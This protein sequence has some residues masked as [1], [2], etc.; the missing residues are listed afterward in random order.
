MRVS[1]RSQ[2]SGMVPSTLAAYFPRL[3]RRW[4]AERPERT[5]SE[6]DGSVV[7]VDV[8]GFT[9]LSERLARLGKIG[10]EEL[11]V[12]ITECFSALLAVADADGGSL[13][14]FGGD[15]LL[16]LFTGPQHERHACGAAVG[17]RRTL[18]QVGRLRTP[19]GQVTLRMSVGVHSGTFHFFLVGDS[20]RELVLTGP[21]TSEVVRMESAAAA[22][23]ILVSPATAAGLPASLVGAEKGPG[24]LLRRQPV[25]DAVE[26][27]RDGLELSDQVLQGYL[28]L[29][30]RERFRAALPE[31][32]HRLVTVGFLH[33]AGA[34]ALVTDHGTDATAAA[35]DDLVRVVQH[36]VDRHGVSFLASDVDRDG[37]KLILAAGAPVAY[38]DDEQG[39]LLALREIMDADHRLAVRAGV[40]R[41]AVFAGDVGPSFRRTYTVMGD[42]VNLAARLMGKAA[43]G[44]I[45]ATGGVL[46][47]TRIRFAT[48]ALEPFHVKGKRRPVH[49]HRVGRVLGTH[50]RDLDAR[51]PL[52]GR[53]AEVAQL[54]AA[55]E[56][57]R[58]G[59]GRLVELVG[60]PG[61]GKSRLLDEMRDR[62]Q[63]MAVHGVA[64][65][66]YESATPYGPFRALLRAL[67]AVPEQTGAQES[68]ALLLNVLHDG[69]PDLLPWAPLL[70]VPLGGQLPATEETAHLDGPFRRQRLHHAVTGLLTAL[71]PAPALLAFEDVHWMDE[72]SADL[73]HH[74]A[75]RVDERPWVV[76]VTRRDAGTGFQARPAP[77]VTSVLLEPLDAEHAAG[78][79]DLVLGAARLPAHARAALAARSG[80]NPLFLAELAGAIDAAAG[81]EELPESVEG[82]ISARIDRLA[83][84]DRTLLR[85]LAVLGQTFTRDLAEAVLPAG[86]RV[87]DDEAWAGLEEFL[88][89]QGGTVRFRHAMIR[90]AAYQAL[91]FRLRRTLHAEAGAAIEAAAGE[92][93][94]EPAALLSYHFFHS[95]RYAEAWRHSLAAAEQAAAVYA[96]ADA[97]TFYQRALEAARGVPDLGPTEVARIH[98]ALGD[99]RDLMGAFVEAGASYRS[100]RRLVAG[101]APAEAR[102]ALKIAKTQG[103]LRRYSQALRSIRRA[104][105]TLDGVD[106]PEAARQRAQL[107]VWHGR[108]CQE[109]GRHAAAI[110]WC[111]EGIADAEAAGEPEAA[112]HAYRV[113]DWA[114]MDL[115]QPEQAVHSGKALAIYEELG[116]LP[117][118]AAVLNNLGGIAYWQGRWN[119]ALGLYERAGDLWTRTG[120]EVGVAFA[121]ANI[122]E[123]LCE[124]GKLGEAEALLRD[125]MRTWQ[126]VGHRPRVAHMKSELARVAARAGR[127]GDA[128]QLFDEAREES[129]D[130]GARVDVLE[131]NARVAESL[132]Y[133]GRGAEALRLA[134]TALEQAQ[135]LGGVGAQSP[136]LHRIRGYALMQRGERAAAARA[137]EESLAAGERR[138]ADYEMALTLRGLA[139]CASASGLPVPPDWLDRSCAILRRLGVVTV[140]EVPLPDSV[141]R[142]AS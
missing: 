57:A 55:L 24:R 116:D 58:R 138:R 96:N 16:L 31:P 23:E 88:H 63:G 131:V 117:G 8:S 74:L 10:A 83:P 77:P 142:P 91:P 84:R 37:G 26:P 86:V 130:V 35:L 67:L 128:A 40:H 70:A 7:F 136:L 32:E 122:A 118:Q 121:R 87:A 90:D 41:G 103:W 79:V 2:T 52:V 99:V 14:K 38:G 62:A 102:L 12:A 71:L 85:H 126:V 4:I 51:V 105:G 107:R 56:A 100:A 133:Q 33:Y 78:L 22:G 66:A 129:N 76:C 98:E 19:A 47:P 75:D 110:D 15:A 9:K 81:V 94:E 134:D 25:R 20:H 125:A 60:E 42:A 124:Q 80:G 53:D 72:A 3:A 97:T 17:M 48:E 34:D 27:P 95:Q 120:N 112:A 64:C 45:L 82:V 132:L 54:T 59:A 127:Y 92:R 123:I 50:R 39:M 1:D 104:L 6:V 141:A 49:A 119:D 108:F 11:S 29:A 65:Q 115:G 135:A 30:L 93:V 13:V 73:L 18:R 43:P 137:F 36:A 69:L 5:T 109:T 140:P 139:A 68:T 101:D 106:F 89:E 61:I 21:A 111:R 113:L 28:P 44:E 46:E 114:Y